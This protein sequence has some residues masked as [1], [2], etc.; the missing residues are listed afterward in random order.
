MTQLLFITLLLGIT[1]CKDKKTTQPRSDSALVS[2]QSDF[3]P[4]KVIDREEGN[5]KAFKTPTPIE[6]DGCSLDAIWDKLDWFGMNYTWMGDVADSTDYQGK[7]KLAWDRNYLYVLVSVVDEHLQPT[8]ADGQENYW[9][10]DYV[11]VFIDEDQSGGNHQYNH[12]AFA[13]HVSTEGHAIDKS[14]TEDT[15]F[16]DDHIQVARSQEGN[17]YLW[18]LAIKLYDNTF[19]ENA[20]DNTSIEILPGKRIGFSIAYGDNDGKASREN[21]MGSKKRHGINNDEGY[22]NADVF[23]S[24]T[25]LE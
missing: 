18:E 19:D 24:L 13:Y 21:F 12:Q 16:F 22:V 23:G 2:C 10:G 6:I 14:T 15:V 3:G 17:H 11:E 5:F 7:F 20:M 4:S 9:K 1:A 25:F 8:L